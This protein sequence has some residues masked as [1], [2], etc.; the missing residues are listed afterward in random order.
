[1]QHKNNFK[2]DVHTAD[3]LNNGFRLYRSDGELKNYD[4]STG[5][6]AVILV[7]GHY[8]A[9]I[10]QMLKNKGPIT[11]QKMI[12]AYCLKAFTTIAAAY[13]SKRG[14]LPRIDVIGDD[15]AAVDDISTYMR[16]GYSG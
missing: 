14:S 8:M 15:A 7:S 1:M 2:F 9:L 12:K 5:L 11:K 6:Y 4:P 16:R 13:N 3:E 10:E